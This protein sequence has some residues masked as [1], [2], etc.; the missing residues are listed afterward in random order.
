MSKYLYLT[1]V[2]CKMENNNKNYLFYAPPFT[3]FFEDECIVV[4]TVNGEAVANVITSCMAE[5]GSDTEKA[6][7]K[8]CGAKGELKKVVGRFI[9]QRFDYKGDIEDE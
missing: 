1:Y 6:L 9:Y 8:L 3:D 4:D 5:N 2:V 7:R